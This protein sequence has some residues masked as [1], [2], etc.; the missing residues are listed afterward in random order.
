MVW[1]PARSVILELGIFHTIMFHV[2][3]YAQAYE[4]FPSLYNPTF[5][6]IL[7][8]SRTRTC[9]R[10]SKPG[11]SEADGRRWNPDRRIAWCKALEVRRGMLL[12]QQT[13][14][15]DPH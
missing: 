2:G 5:S 7:L 4:I 14:E 1:D 8:Q 10:L 3:L 6:L 12:R 15:P 11:G 13:T 9:D